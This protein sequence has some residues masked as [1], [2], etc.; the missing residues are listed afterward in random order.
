MSKARL[1]I[2]ALFVEGQTASEVA[3]R[4][5]VHRAWVYKLKARYLAEGEAAFEPRSRRPKTSP[6]A[7]PVETVELVL[8]LR[9]QL[10]GAGLDAGA[11]TIGWHLQHHH[12]VRLSR[13]TIHRILTRAGA[14][15]SDPGKRPRCS[16]TG[17]EATAVRAALEWFDYT[18]PPR[19]GPDQ[20]PS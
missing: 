12:Q 19:I 7:T 4:Y 8:R 11:D 6:R 1:V 20:V 10:A 18:D 17:L 13:A 5:G 2:T 14:V 16:Y 9:K 3:R 15:I